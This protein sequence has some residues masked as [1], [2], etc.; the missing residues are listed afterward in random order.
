MLALMRNLGY[1]ENKVSSLCDYINRREELLPLVDS[2][3]SRAKR[4]VLSVFY[5]GARDDVPEFCKSLARE[6]DAVADTLKVAWCR[7]HPTYRERDKHG[8]LAIMLR[9]IEKSC[10]FAME[11][12][13]QHGRQFMTYNHDGGLVRKLHNEKMSCQS[14]Q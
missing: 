11:E 13:R 7:D 14:I 12:L 6:V 10:L 2:D 3:R 8:V 4:K 9:D 5:G 1:P